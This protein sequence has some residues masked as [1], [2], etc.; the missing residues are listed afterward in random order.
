MKARMVDR[1]DEKIPFGFKFFFSFEFWNV[2]DLKL[3]VI[4][5]AKDPK[6]GFSR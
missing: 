3:N 6:V 2:K 1:G 5:L 4:L